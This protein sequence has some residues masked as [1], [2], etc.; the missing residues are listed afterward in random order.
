MKQIK[1]FYKDKPVMEFE[2]EIDDFQTI[3]E[4]LYTKYKGAIGFEINS[5]DKVK[6]IGVK[7][8]SKY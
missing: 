1:I 8:E 7:D 6:E 4:I 5:I 2:T 3:I